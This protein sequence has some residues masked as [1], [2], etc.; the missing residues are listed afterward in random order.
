MRS[1]GL[2]L[3]G[4]EERTYDSIHHTAKP[5]EEIDRLLEGFG[6]VFIIGCGTCTTLTRTGG[7]A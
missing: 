1:A 6:R 3:T 5:E 4:H 2:Q 7:G